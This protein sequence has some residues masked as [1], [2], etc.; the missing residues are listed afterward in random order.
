MFPFARHTQIH[1][2]SDYMWWADAN[3][4]HFKDESTEAVAVKSPADSHAA[5][6]GQRKDHSP[7]QPDSQ[8]A[9]SPAMP[10]C[11]QG[12]APGLWAIV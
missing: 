11:H 12:R 6:E 4:P 3:F 9:H 10:H 1:I 2:A 8:N 7:G 5:N